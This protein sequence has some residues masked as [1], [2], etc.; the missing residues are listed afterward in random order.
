M[1]NR[2]NPHIYSNNIITPEQF[3]FRKD[4]NMETVIYTLTTYILKALDEH[5]QTLQIFC[6]LRKAFD[7]AIHDIL[8]D[9]L[10][11]YGICGKTIMWFKSYLKYRNAIMRREKYIQTG[12]L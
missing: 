6:D 3:G 11:I 10:F 1:Y 8:L 2:L 12:K 5:S 9:K 7:C 4:R